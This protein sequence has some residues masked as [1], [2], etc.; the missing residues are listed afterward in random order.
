MGKYQEFAQDE[1]EEHYLEEAFALLRRKPPTRQG[2]SSDGDGRASVLE[3]LD[4]ERRFLRAHDRESSRA[5]AQREARR[6]EIEIKED[7]APEVRAELQRWDPARWWDRSNFDYLFCHRERL[8]NIYGRAVQEQLELVSAKINYVSPEGRDGYFKKLEQNVGW[9][10]HILP[11]IFCRSKYADRLARCGLWVNAQNSRRCH[12]C[13]LCP[14][15]HWNDI[16]KVLVQA[17]GEN[18]GAFANAPCWT[19]IT[20]GFTT[21]RANSKAVGRPLTEDDF[22]HVRGDDDY[23]AFPT[24][25]GNDDEAPDHFSESYDDARILA[26]VVQEAL[27]ELYQ[28]Q[29]VDGYRNKLESAFRVTPGAAAWVNMHGHAIG[30]GRETNLQFIADS[31]AELMRAG[32]RRHRKKL[33]GDYHPD[34]LVLGVESA[35]DLVSCIVYSEKVVPVAAIAEDAMLKPGAVVGDGAPNGEYVH[36]L[37]ESLNDLIDEHIPNLFSQFKL[38]RE[39]CWLRRRK[40]V[41]NMKF[42]DNDTFVGREPDWHARA[43]RKKAKALKDKRAEARTRQGSPGAQQGKQQK[44][45]RKNPRRLART[46]S[47]NTSAI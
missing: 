14:L 9:L 32:L 23:D 10:D 8:G 27:D 3:G 36:G 13:D 16:L 5:R 24:R 39:T 18:S 15:C 11:L 19:F 47:K 35:P 1:I 7:C 2:D 6:R 17:F 12:K 41:G 4:E 44:R 28:R 46:L 31:L 45:T 25:I 20:C 40:T 26:V 43:R 37:D 42:S 33:L 30:N 38:D 34:V 29:I 22:H 21:N